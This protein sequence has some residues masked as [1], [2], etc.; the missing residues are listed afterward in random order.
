[1]NPVGGLANRMRAIASTYLQAQ[2]LNLNLI[3]YWF[4]DK[5]LN[6]RF[7]DLFE[8]PTEKGII[9]K[10]GNFIDFLKFSGKRKKTMFF[11]KFYEKYYFDYSFTESSQK[12]YLKR[13]EEFS[14]GGKR[15]YIQSCGFIGNHSKLNLHNCLKT[16]FRL[17]DDVN[18][19]LLKKSKDFGNN[20]VGFHIRRTDNTFSISNSPSS[21]FMEKANHELVR[22]PQVSLFLASD[23]LNEKQMFK[24]VYPCVI[25]ELKET[26]R[27]NV[28]GIKDG[29]ID[30]YLL[31]K[32]DRVYG[33]FYS[34]FS[35]LASIIGNNE[36]IVLKN[37]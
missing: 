31:S 12:K 18:D 34:S 1:M 8:Y 32:C 2:N 25:T 20:C 13:L 29:L 23:S 27:D 21:L 9:I 5:E 15:V 24:K 36:L 19:T 6:A 11:S 4:R 10:E 35:E 28:E 33:S 14:W 7:C 16:L 22:N 26:S 37:E 3:V 30:M 17:K